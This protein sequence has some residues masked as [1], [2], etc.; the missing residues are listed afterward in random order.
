MTRTLVA[1]AVLVALGAAG[2]G[3]SRTV[4]VTVTR[5]RTVTVTAPTSTG[6]TTG[7][8]TAGACTGGQLGGVFT[9][10]A[11]SAGAGQISY[12]L[13]LTNTG[14]AACFVSGL[15]VVQLL[16][17][18]GSPLP[19]HG[20]A[21]RPGTQ[22]AARVV[23]APRASAT[24]QARFS[25]DVHGSGEQQTGPCEPTAITLRVDSDRRWHGRRSHQA[26]DERLRARLH[27]ALAVR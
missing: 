13:T 3:G 6:T 25:P 7:A 22:T 16:D 17:K 19:T 9:T 20:S 1:G 23:L 4:T 2:C 27:A 10:I 8:S 5:T 15:P 18:N 24:A 12:L 14:S 26:G 21:A 11:G